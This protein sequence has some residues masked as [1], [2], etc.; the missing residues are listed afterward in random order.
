MSR[1]FVIA[2]LVLACTA[3]AAARRDF[4]EQYRAI[5]ADAPNGFS[6]FR[7]DQFGEKPFPVAPYGQI[8]YY[9]AKGWPEGALACHIE[10]R[11]EETD[12]GHRFPNYYCEFP[13]LA[14]DKG[15]ALRTLAGR[16]A[17]CLKGSSRPAGNGLDRNG[18]MLSWHSKDYDV[19]YSGFAGP[20]NPNIRILIQAERK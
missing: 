6:L 3:Q 10:M 17:S 19:H 8:N 12:D 14:S 7:G 9:V 11:D 16:I 18:G 20:S 5:A 13:T 2:L 1:W 15:K 4:C